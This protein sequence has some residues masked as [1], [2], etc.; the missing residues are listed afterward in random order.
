MENNST[1]S[2]SSISTWSPAFTPTTTTVV[3]GVEIQVPS[4]MTIEVVGNKVKVLYSVVT[5]QY[6]QVTYTGQ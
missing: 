1:V 6:P 2:V 4:G 3:S 5:Y